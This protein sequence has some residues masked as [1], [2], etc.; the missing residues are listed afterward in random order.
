MVL[1]LDV[2][3]SPDFRFTILQHYPRLLVLPVD[4]RLLIVRQDR[5]TGLLSLHAHYTIQIREM[6]Y[7]Q[8]KFWYLSHPTRA[9][10]RPTLQARLSRRRLMGWTGGVSLILVLLTAKHVLIKTSRSASRA[11]E[12]L[13]MSELRSDQQFLIYIPSMSISPGFLPSNTH[14]GG[15]AGAICCTY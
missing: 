6:P 9:S 4:R 10:L 1:K 5:E 15:L 8:N 3:F 2:I 14:I 12:M 13:H 11:S 7:R